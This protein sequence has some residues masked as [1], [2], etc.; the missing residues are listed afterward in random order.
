MQPLTQADDTFFGVGVTGCPSLPYLVVRTHARD[1]APTTPKHRLTRSNVLQAGTRN[2][3]IHDALAWCNAGKKHDGVGFLDF[4]RSKSMQFPTP[5]VRRPSFAESRRLFCGVTA[6]W[7]NAALTGAGA[8]VVLSPV[9]LP[10]QP[11]VPPAPLSAALSAQP[12]RR[13]PR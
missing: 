9:W 6:L 10:L 2:D 13:G 8:A 4:V 1:I 11:R 3:E 12:P 5:K 7:L